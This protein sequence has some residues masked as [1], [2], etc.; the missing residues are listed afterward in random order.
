MSTELCE[1]LGIEQRSFA[2]THCPGVVAT[3]SGTDGLGALGGRA[4]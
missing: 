4:R 1:W 2:F 3:V